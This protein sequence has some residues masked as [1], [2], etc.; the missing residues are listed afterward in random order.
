MTNPPI[1]WVPP[2]GFDENLPGLGLPELVEASHQIIYNP[3]PSGANTDEGGDGVYESLEHGTF[4]HGP[5]ATVIGDHI[6]VTFTNHT[7]DEGGPGERHIARVGRIND[8]GEDIDW[9]GYDRFAAT[10]PPPIAAFRRKFQTDLDTFGPYS[11]GGISVINGRIYCNVRLTATIGFTNEQQY[12]HTSGPIPVENYSDNMDIESGYYFDKWAEVDFAGI[13]QWEI[14]DDRLIP[15]SPLYERVPFRSR[16]EVTPGRFKESRPLLPPYSTAVPYEKAPAQIR[17]DVAQMEASPQTAKAMFRDGENHLSADGKH[18]LAHL[19]EF[20]R[21]DGSL[22][23]I[24]DNLQ[25]A[26]HY[27]ASERASEDDFYP[28]GQETRLMGGANPT[29]GQL[30]DGRPYIIGNEYDDYYHAPEKSRKDMYITVSEDGRTFDKTWLLKHVD[31]EPD[32]GIYKYGGPQYFN[33]IVLGDN[34]WIFYSITKQQIG[35]T[36]VPLS[37]LK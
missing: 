4:C 12:R 7:R 13:Q 28:P 1:T 8:G 24:R 30:P 35:L 10:A 23:V 21:P 37:A 2:T 20:T 16:F 33:E 3:K 9:G 25:N 18:A 32:G 22:V 5:R 31:G 34:M 17:D 27:Y 15:V 19:G 6:V 26:G 36:R 14:E 11:S 29:T